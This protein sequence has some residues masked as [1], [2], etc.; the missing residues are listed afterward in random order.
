MLVVLQWSLVDTHR[1][2]STLCCPNTFLAEDEQGD[3]AL[4]PVSA[5]SLRTGFLSAV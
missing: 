4:L 3:G 5:L 2:V 1:T